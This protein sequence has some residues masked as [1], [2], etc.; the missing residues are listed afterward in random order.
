[1]TNRTVPERF[2][3]DLKFT[4]MRKGTTLS[5]DSYTYTSRLGARFLVEYFQTAPGIIRYMYFKIEDPKP[6]LQTK[7]EMD[8]KTAEKAA[9]TLVAGTAAVTVMSHCLGG[10]GLVYYSLWD[11]DSSILRRK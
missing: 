6:K 8:I 10:G 3:A 11:G 4:K 1:M 9:V 5:N 7:S 2:E